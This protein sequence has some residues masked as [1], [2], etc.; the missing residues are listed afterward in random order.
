VFV[1]TT[2]TTTSVIGPVGPVIC[3]GVPP[4]TAATIPVAM[5]P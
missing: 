3:T 5:A 2:P 4:N 1:A